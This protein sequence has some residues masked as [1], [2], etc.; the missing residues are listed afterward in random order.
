MTTIFADCRKLDLPVDI[1]VFAWGLL[2]LLTMHL[3]PVCAAVLLDEGLVKEAPKQ[4]RF[5]KTSSGYM[6]PYTR[7]IP[8]TDVTFTMLPIP[9]GQFTLGSPE[10]EPGREACEGP[11]VIVEIAPFWM[12][13]HEITWAEFKQYMALTDIFRDFDARGIRRVTKDR[14]IDAVTAPSKL[15]DPDATFES[16]EDPGQPAVMMTQYAAKQYTKWLS[17]LTGQFYRLPAEAEWEY[18]CRA[19]T[20][21]SFYFGNDA[22]M[23]GDYAWYEVNS[24][25]RSHKVGQKKP[26]PWG[27]YDM[28]GNVAEWVLD[29]YTETGYEELE[30]ELQAGRD[31]IHWPTSA[32][33]RVVRG[34]SFEMES[35][36]CRSAA[37]MG[38]DDDEWKTD[39]PNL[40]ASPWWLTTT[41]ATGVGFRIAR[42][43]KT[44]NDPRT[45][46]RFWNADAVEIVE[47]V[48]YRIHE[49]ESGAIGIVDRE[50]PDAIQELKRKQEDQR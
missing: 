28:H 4:G 50:L 39:D 47:D 37:R 32:F 5:V 18:A 36:Q 11:Q 35:E 14:Q 10:S 44:P 2:L 34:G 3:R 16:G 42:P 43:L 17:G 21:T 9:G 15:Y 22:S 7:K 40:P 48:E 49:Q 6:V 27:L 45:R 31:V 33:P 24:R 8:G 19:S 1:R 25:E 20:K 30:H 23:L 12:S 38:S 46:E 13:A 29:E 26:N 41:P